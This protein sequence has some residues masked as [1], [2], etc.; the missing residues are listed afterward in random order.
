MKVSLTNDGPVT[1]LAG[2][3]GAV[4]NA[5]T[6]T[7]DHIVVAARSLDEGRAWCRETL[8]SKPAEAASTTVCYAQYLAQVGERSDERRYLEIIAIDA[9]AGRPGFRAGSVWTAPRVAGRSHGPARLVACCCA[10]MPDAIERFAATPGYAANVGDRRR[11]A[12]SAGA[13]RSRRTASASP[14]ALPHL[15]HRGR[16]RPSG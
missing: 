10:G 2:F 3:G 16:R 12:T 15:I 9:D 1:I 11:A 5:V 8:G 14:V 6:T 4:M 13:S 7:L